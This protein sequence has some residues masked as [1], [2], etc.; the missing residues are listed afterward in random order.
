[1]ITL[2]VKYFM[3]SISIIQL[4]REDGKSRQ[5]SNGD[6]ESPSKIA[7]E[8]LISSEAVYLSVW[9]KMRMVLPEFVITF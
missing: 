7:Q 2:L 4:R 1:M 9:F 8:I 3:P 5:N 6:N